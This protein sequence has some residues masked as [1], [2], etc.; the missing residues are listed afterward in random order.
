MRIKD[1]LRLCGEKE[2]TEVELYECDERESITVTVV[3]LFADDRYKDL[4]ESEIAS[5]DYNEDRVLCI[6]YFMEEE[7]E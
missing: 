3:E 4:M 7:G 1:L 6:Y 5:W 2:N